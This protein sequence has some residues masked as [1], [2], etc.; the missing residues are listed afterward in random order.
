MKKYLMPVL[1][2]CG[3]LLYV[4]VYFLGVLYMIP[5]TLPRMLTLIVF[6]AG[7]AALAVALVFVLIQR[8]K[9]IKEEEKDDLS[10][11]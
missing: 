2:V 4:I 1:I 5:F 3:I 10:Q 9:E 6:I 8:I 11:Y 7:G